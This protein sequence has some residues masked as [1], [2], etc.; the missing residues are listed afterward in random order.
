MLRGPKRP[1]APAKKMMA[2]PMT[3]IKSSGPKL[4]TMSSPI[5]LSAPTKQA[6]PTVKNSAPPSFT[7]R[8]KLM[9][10]SMKNKP[11]VSKDMKPEPAAPVMMDKPKRKAPV[12]RSTAIRKVKKVAAP[13]KK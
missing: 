12:K 4:M 5:K 10:D 11:K 6:S 3:I 13:K 9:A 2:S 1:S 8:L 7:E